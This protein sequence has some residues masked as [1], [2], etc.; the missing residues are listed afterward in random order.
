[1]AILREKGTTPEVSQGKVFQLEQ[2]V[3]AAELGIGVDGPDKV[4]IVTSDRSASTYAEQLQEI[5]V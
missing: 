5:L 3:R 1:V 2:I 4:E